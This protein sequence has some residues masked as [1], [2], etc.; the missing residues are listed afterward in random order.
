M[1][2]FVASLLQGSQNLAG[3]KSFSFREQAQCG[4]NM[5]QLLGTRNKAAT[6]AHPKAGSTHDIDRL[7]RKAVRVWDEVAG[8]A[9]L[10]FTSQA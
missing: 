6:A 10:V 5:S 9:F 2:G 7:G 8:P 3:A 4:V 1:I